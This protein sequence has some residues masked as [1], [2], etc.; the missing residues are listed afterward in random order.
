MANRPTWL[1]EETTSAGRENLDPA[2]TSRYDEKEDADAAGE[3]KLLIRLGLGP[4]SHVL[5]MGAGTGQFALAA[6]R[7]CSRVVAVDVSPLML[8]ELR[9]K[10]VAVGASN[11]EAVEAG[12]LTYEHEGAPVDFVYSRYALHHLPDFWKA[13]ALQRLHRILRPGGVL[14]L[15]DVVYHFDPSKARERLDRWCATIGDDVEDGWTRADLIEHIRDEHSTFTWL[16]ESMLD[17]AGFAVEEA[18][19]S[20]DGI[21][22][23]YIARAR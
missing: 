8:T 18:V 6:S 16:L 17:R 22:A 5:D 15:W 10:I 4:D 14:R 2:H 21:F 9:T 11:L 7:V 3:L 13:L 23:R 12:F 1:L 19:Y 20:A